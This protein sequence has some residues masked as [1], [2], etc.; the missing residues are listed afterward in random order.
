MKLAGLV[1]IMVSAISVGARVASSLKKRCMDIRQLLHALQVFK[2]ELMF[3]S[4]P[5]PRAFSVL[6]ASVDGHFSTLFSVMSQ[7]MEANRWM[8]PKTAMEKSLAEIQGEVPEEILLELAGKIGKYDLSAQ[9][10]GI[11]QAME[12]AAQLLKTMEEERSIKSKTYKTLSICAGVATV[13]LLL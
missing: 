13:I 8:T 11:E 3:S 12:Q 9:I 6:A 7:K 1:F 10:I 5:L 2:N 4:V